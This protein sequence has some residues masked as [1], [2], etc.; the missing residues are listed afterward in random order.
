V[1]E[2]G[3]NALPRARASPKKGGGGTPEPREG[4]FNYDRSSAVSCTS[5]VSL[6]LSLF[7]PSLPPFAFVRDR[8]VAQREPLRMT[9]VFLRNVISHVRSIHA[10]EASSRKIITRRS[11]RIEFIPWIPRARP[12][13]PYRQ[14]R[15]SPTL[16]SDSP[17]LAEA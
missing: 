7:L 6:S 13:P 1:G 4:L 10:H 11:T 5:S 12:P 16:P 14:Y 17:G 8:G 2:T 15:L 9:N 3:C